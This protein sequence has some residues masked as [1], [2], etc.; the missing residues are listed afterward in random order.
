M[1]NVNAAITIVCQFANVLI[2]NR[3]SKAAGFTYQGSIGPNNLP[4][5]Y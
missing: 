4:R 5:Q 3:A 1:V 2:K